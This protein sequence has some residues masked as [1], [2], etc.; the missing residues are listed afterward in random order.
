[1]PCRFILQFSHIHARFLGVSSLNKSM[2]SWDHKSDDLAVFLFKISAFRSFFTIKSV[3]PTFSHRSD[4]TSFTPFL[5]LPILK[6]DRFKS[7]Y[8]DTVYLDCPSSE[9]L[10]L[11]VAVVPLTRTLM[12]HNIVLCKSA[13]HCEKICVILMFT[14]KFK[15]EGMCVC[16][17]APSWVFS[18]GVCVCVCV[19]V[20][21]G[22]CTDILRDSGSNQ[23][24]WLKPEKGTPSVTSIEDKGNHITALQQS[25]DLQ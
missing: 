21:A 13:C 24:K 18:A 25:A 15:L 20:C 7:D 2:A 5:Y 22:P 12:F 8:V 19:C 23:K 16:V 9:N 10:T 3:P 6:C 17:C 4:L 14:S 11:W 1:M